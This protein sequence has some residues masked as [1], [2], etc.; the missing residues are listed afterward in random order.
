MVHRGPT[1]QVRK[2]HCGTPIASIDCPYYAEKRCVLRYLHSLTIAKGP[3]A[4]REV[5]GE[6]PD[7]RDKRFRH[8]DLPLVTRRIDT[9]EGDDEVDAE[10]GHQV[11]VG[12]AAPRIGM[13]LDARLVFWSTWR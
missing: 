8:D 4:R 5:A 9:E 13:V 7:F 12:L 6:D 3:A 1:L 10:S 2:S 11:G